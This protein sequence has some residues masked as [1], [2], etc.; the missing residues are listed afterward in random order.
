MLVPFGLLFTSSLHRGSFVFRG[1]NVCQPAKSMADDIG[2]LKA[3]KGSVRW[4]RAVRYQL[5]KL[6]VEESGEHV[7]GGRL[8]PMEPSASCPIFA[9]D[10]IAAKV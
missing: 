8:E 7:A 10:S 5:Q 9:V 2:D 1:Q 6:A 4:A 3:E